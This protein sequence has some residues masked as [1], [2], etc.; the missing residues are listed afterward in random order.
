MTNDQMFLLAAGVW[1]A[2]SIFA[3]VRIQS[4]RSEMASLKQGKKDAEIDDRTK[5]LSDAELDALVSK[6]LGGTKPSA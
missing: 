5:R 3:E 2:W 6:D 1:A 4:L